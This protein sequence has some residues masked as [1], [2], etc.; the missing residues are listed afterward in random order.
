VL[1]SSAISVLQQGLVLFPDS[2]SGRI[3]IPSGLA[4]G[5]NAHMD[6]T[7]VNSQV[8]IPANA[9]LLYEI[10][11]I[12]VMSTRFATDTAA[13]GNFLRTNSVEPVPLK[14]VSGIRYTIDNKGQTS[15]DKPK[16]GDGV[17]VT[18]SENFLTSLDTAKFI[19]KEFAWKDQ[20]TAWRIMLPKYLTVGSTITMYVPSGYAHGS[21]T[22]STTGATIPINSNMIYKVTLV[23]IKPH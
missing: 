21:S 8:T 5:I 22:I 20:V 12:G 11:L 9:N 2:S 7:K 6:T 23:E 3:Y 19:T 16:S 15:T 14:D 18:Y 1:L 13:I 4:F 17:L 10:K